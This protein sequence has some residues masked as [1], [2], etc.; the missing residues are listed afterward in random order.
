MT[1][2]NYLELNGEKNNA[3]VFLHGNSHSKE[4]FAAQI[5]D[6]NLNEYRLLFV[7]LPGHGDSLKTGNYSLKQ[8]GKIIADFI[9]TL[10]ADKVI[11]VGHSLGGHVAINALKTISPE[12]LFLFGTPPL[13]N[14]IDFSAFLAN[15]KAQALSQVDSNMNDIEQLMDEL[16]YTGTNKIR[17]IADYLK[18]DSRFRQ[19]IFTDVIANQHEDEIKM[20]NS[21]TGEVMVL[22]SSNDG[23]VNNTYI[24]TVM[25]QQSDNTTLAEIHAGHSPHVERPEE[26]NSLLCQFCTRVFNKDLTNNTIKNYQTYGI[27][28]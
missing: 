17:G 21:F 18:T 15:P 26:F 16:G 9:S 24:K 3:I 28:L 27:Q 7:D 19:E 23:L 8:I 1:D 20:I 14:P 22:L 5:A 25:D 11:I 13:K 10:N 2:L 12:A 4:S 6:T